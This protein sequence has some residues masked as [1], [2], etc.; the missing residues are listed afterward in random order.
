MVK[1]N[2]ASRSASTLVL[3]FYGCKVATC[4][5]ITSLEVLGIK[6]V[7]KTKYLRSFAFI[8]LKNYF[9]IL[10]DVIINRIREAYDEIL[11]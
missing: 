8:H 10:Y 4:M 3:L 2:R 9:P 1:S 5:K 6:R 7:Y 11:F